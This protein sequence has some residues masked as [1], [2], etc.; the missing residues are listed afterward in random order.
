MKY[1]SLLQQSR[2]YFRRIT[3]YNLQPFVLKIEDIQDGL[4]ELLHNIPNNSVVIALFYGYITAKETEEQFKENIFHASNFST[5]F[6]MNQRD[7]FSSPETV[8]S[9]LHYHHCIYG[10]YIFVINNTD[11]YEVNHI[12]NNYYQIGITSDELIAEASLLIEILIDV[13]RNFLLLGNLKGLELIKIDQFLYFDFYVEHFNF[14]PEVMDRQ[15]DIVIEALESKI[16][17]LSNEELNA[18]KNKII[19]KTNETYS[20]LYEKALT[21]WQEIYK[22]TLQFKRSN[23]EPFIEKYTKDQLIQFFKK[24]FIEK[25]S[26]KKISIQLYKNTTEHF[27]QINTKTTYRLN[28]EIESIVTNNLDLL[29]NL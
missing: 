15:L 7:Y 5:I 9:H 13:A 12:V 29:S 6:N 27:P 1:L 2:L 21:V 28:P 17:R 23:I 19:F 10:S 26:L 24:I 8:L 14:N 16:R 25:Q 4:E 20:T 11:Y 3:K 18:Y 22:N